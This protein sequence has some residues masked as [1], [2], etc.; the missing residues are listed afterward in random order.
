MGLSVWSPADPAVHSIPASE[1][2]LQTADLLHGHLPKDRL[3]Q[4]ITPK[5]F[6]GI[7]F[8][9]VTT[10]SDVSSERPLDICF[11][12]AAPSTSSGTLYL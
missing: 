4:G 7:V 6:R 11:I 2:I 10:L 1:R 5:F 9:S 8:L 12:S 3:L